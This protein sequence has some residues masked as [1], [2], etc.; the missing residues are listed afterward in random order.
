VI[1]ALVA[2]AQSHLELSVQ[3]GRLTQEEADARLAELTERITRR[4][5]EGR[6]TDD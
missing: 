2:E 4:V 1:D 3:N 6:P 5:N